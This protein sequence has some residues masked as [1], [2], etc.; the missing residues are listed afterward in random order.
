MALFWDAIS[1]SLIPLIATPIGLYIR[2]KDPKY[3]PVIMSIVITEIVISFSR[4]LPAFHPVMMRPSGAKNC[5]LFNSGGSYD[6]Q[7]AMPS[8]HMMLTT[9][10]TFSIL[11]LYA[12][13][14]NLKTIAIAKPAALSSAIVYIF[15]M[16]GSRIM[17]GCHNISQVIIGGIIGFALAYVLY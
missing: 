12:R 17:R 16:A 2:T 13:T 14:K 1:L 11:F 5:N 9:C 10:I 4:Q 7:L 3:I 6:G 15:L 8:G